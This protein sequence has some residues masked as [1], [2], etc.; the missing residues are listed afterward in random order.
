MQKQKQNSKGQHDLGSFLGFLKVFEDDEQ[1]RFIL[2]KGCCLGVLS[3]TKMTS[4]LDED[5]GSSCTMPWLK[6]TI[7]K[8]S[9]TKIYNSRQKHVQ[10][11]R[12]CSKLSLNYFASASF[13]TTL[14]S[15]PFLTDLAIASSSFTPRTVKATFPL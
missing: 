3:S 10:L 5:V 13:L 14:P 6:I 15:S 12:T 8:A 4:G 9:V 11:V 1:S 7:K 2:F